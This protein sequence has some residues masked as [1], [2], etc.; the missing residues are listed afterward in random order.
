MPI[1]RYNA[2]FGGKPGS[3]QKAHDAMMK[4]YGAK[5]G[6]SVFYAMVNKKKPGLIRAARAAKARG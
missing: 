5:E 4:E 3:A 6:T 2:A 1:S